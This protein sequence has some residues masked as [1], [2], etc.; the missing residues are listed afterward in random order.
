MKIFLDSG[1]FGAWKR[2]VDLDLSEYIAFIRQNRHH[3]ENYV[4]LDVIPGHDGQCAV[5]P[6]AI[7]HAAKCSHVNHCRMKDAGLSPI[8]VFHR[9]ERFEWL[10]KMME[11]RERYI[12]LAPLPWRSPP[13]VVA[14]WIDDC[15][16]LLTDRHGR[17]KTKSPRSRSDV[18]L[19]ALPASV[20]QRR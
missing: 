3:I 13:L 20:V 18:V 10:A 12:A 9:Q 7:E 14:R 6:E 1:A 17:T 2:G 19:P 16:S 11:E 15:F 8:A 5:D 4:T